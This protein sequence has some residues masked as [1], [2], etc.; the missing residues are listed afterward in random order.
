MDYFFLFLFLPP[1]FLFFL[2]FLFFLA[3]S[4]RLEASDLLY[5]DAAPKKLDLARRFALRFC[6]DL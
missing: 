1:A 6:A 4:R 2:F 5:S 3:Y